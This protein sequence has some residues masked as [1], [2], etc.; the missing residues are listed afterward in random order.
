MS[1]GV[2]TLAFVLNSHKMQT[3]Y[4]ESMTCVGTGVLDCQIVDAKI[5]LLGGA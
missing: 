4:C 1:L 2:H 3:A 5:R